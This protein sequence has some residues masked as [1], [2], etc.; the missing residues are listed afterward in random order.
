MGTTMKYSMVYE[1]PWWRERGTWVA[2]GVGFCFG[3]IFIYEGRY[4]LHTHTHTLL[5]PRI[6]WQDDISQHVRAQQLCAQLPLSFTHQVILGFVLFVH[7]P[8]ASTTLHILGA[9]VQRPKTCSMFH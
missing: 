6:P 1:K 5:Q 3:N 4:L 2:Q 9:A 8:E 7:I